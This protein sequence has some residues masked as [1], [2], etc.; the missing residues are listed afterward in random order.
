[1]PAGKRIVLST[2]GSFGEIHPYSAIALE[3]KA[4]GH[5]PVM[6]TSEVY[7][8]KMDA[9]GLEFRPVRPDIPSFDQPDELSRLAVELI[10][11]RGGTEKVLGLF[12]QNL[13]EIYEDLDG[14]VE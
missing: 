6:A 1:M 12:T 7:R 14:I 3:L 13:P 8:E 2:F 11:A 9:L 10:E 5:S 4:R